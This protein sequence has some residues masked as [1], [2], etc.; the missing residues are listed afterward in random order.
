MG[1]EERKG[2][3]EETEAHDGSELTQKQL[4]EQEKQTI[5]VDC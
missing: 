5:S 4:N 2:Q 3:R 1:R